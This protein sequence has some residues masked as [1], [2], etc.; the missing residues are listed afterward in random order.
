MFGLDFALLMPTFYIIGSSLYDT[1]TETFSFTPISTLDGWVSHVLSYLIL[2]FSIDVPHFEHHL[3]WYALIME[4]HYSVRRS[5]LMSNVLGKYTM[6]LALT[7][8]ELSPIHVRQAED[9]PENRKIS[10]FRSRVF[11]HV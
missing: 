3:H 10:D 8:L 11:P 7:G 1:A 5:K 4:N 2:Q 6:V 9:I